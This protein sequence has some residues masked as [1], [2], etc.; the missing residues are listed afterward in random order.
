MSMAMFV[1]T[2]LPLTGTY[3]ITTGVDTTYEGVNVSNHSGDGWSSRKVWLAIGSSALATALLV[4]GYIDQEVWKWFC[5]G[6]IISYMGS[7]AYIKVKNGK[8]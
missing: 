4:M 2:G 7:N 3:K 1:D 6:T 8:Q 5:G